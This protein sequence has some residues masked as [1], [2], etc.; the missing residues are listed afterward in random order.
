MIDVT[1]LP[2]ELLGM[3]LFAV[4]VARCRIG[5]VRVAYVAAPEGGYATQNMDLLESDRWLSKGVTEVRSIV[6]FPGKFS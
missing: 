4:S 2:R 5:S 6:G 3:L 1:C